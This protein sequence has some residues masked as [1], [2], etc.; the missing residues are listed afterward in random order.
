MTHIMIDVETLGTNNDSQ[1]LSIGACEFTSSGAIKNKFYMVVKLE[2]SVHV[3]VTPGTLKFWATQGQELANLLNDPNA[4]HIMFVLG[5]LSRHFNWDGAS[6]WANGTK[7]D[8]GMLEE[9]Y[10]TNNLVIPWKYN[11][12]RCMRTIKQFAGKIDISF[13]GKPHHALDDA[14]WQALYVSIACAKLG[15]ELDNE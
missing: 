14:V 6:L 15:L 10:K 3:K 11:S 12:D 1:I 9:L 4:E 7:F 5:A 2:D 13:E 8:I